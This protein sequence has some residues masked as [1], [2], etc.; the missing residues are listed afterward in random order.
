LK[1]WKGGMN[2]TLKNHKGIK[3][4]GDGEKNLH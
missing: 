2:Y 4:F 3:Q 1:K